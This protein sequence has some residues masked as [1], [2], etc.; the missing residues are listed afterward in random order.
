M[1]EISHYTYKFV[2]DNRIVIYG[3]DII[4]LWNDIYDIFDL[5]YE[6]YIQRNHGREMNQK[7]IRELREDF[8]EDLDEDLLLINSQYKNKK[9]YFWNEGTFWSNTHEEHIEDIISLYEEMEYKIIRNDNDSI[10][11]DFFVEKGE[12]KKAILCRQWFID[13]GDVERGKPDILKFLNSSIPSHEKLII[14]FEPIHKEIIELINNNAEF[15]STDDIRNQRNWYVSEKLD[16]KAK[17]PYFIEEERPDWILLKLINEVN[18][19]KTNNEKKISLEKASC[20]LF[21]NIDGFQVEKENLRSSAEESDLLVSNE[22]NDKFFEKRGSPILVECRN[23]K[24][25][26][27]AKDAR[28]F[29]GKISNLGLTCGVIISK[30][31]LSGKI[32]RDAKL[33]IRDSRKDGVT[34]IP[35]EIRD[36][37]FIA[38]GSD[39]LKI[40]K[41]K[42]YDLFHF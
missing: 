19:S 18:K 32:N 3:N 31:G 22:S 16:E 40:M 13:E 14:N 11:C 12:E 9:L 6:M 30:R 25:S 23:V 38:N 10:Y 42:Y 41:K 27:S 34:I 4:Q 24:K 5:H 36:I 15:E 37:E 26:F 33:E 20:Y 35:L 29:K 28:D 39:P 17:D 8:F 1:S 21:N 2:F 7:E